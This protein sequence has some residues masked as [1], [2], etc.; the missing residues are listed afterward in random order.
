MTAG[1]RKAARGGGL[2]PPPPWGRGP[3]GGAPG[4][5][6]PPT[7]P[8]GWHEF[9]GEGLETE[10]A[11]ATAAFVALAARP[12]AARGEMV[13]VCR[14]DDLHAPGLAGLGFPAERLIQVCARDEAETLAVLEDAL[15]TP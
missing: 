13:W 10:T 9:V 1:A 4:N 12:L 8:G 2:I 6:P 14:R 3:G 7:A 15:R 11:A 5:Q